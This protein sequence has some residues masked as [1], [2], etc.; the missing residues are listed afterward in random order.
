MRYKNPHTPRA[1]E[2][3]TLIAELG[4]EYLTTKDIAALIDAHGFSTQTEIE[5][6]LGLPHTS[7]GFIPGVHR[8]KLKQLLATQVR[9]QRAA[10]IS[11]VLRRAEPIKSS[12]EI[13]R[14]FEIINNKTVHTMFSE[15]YPGNSR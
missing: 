13:M 15:L 3:L 14:G 5:T 10:K 7:L 6:H 2:R 11:K 4:L 8:E 9:R 12:E 1:I